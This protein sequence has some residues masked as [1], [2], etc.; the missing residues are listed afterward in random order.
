MSFLGSAWPEGPTEGPSTCRAWLNPDSTD[1]AVS[2]V[3]D[4]AI[5]AFLPADFSIIAPFREWRLVSPS[6]IRRLE[7]S[8]RRLSGLWS[9]MPGTP[10]RSRFPAPW[11]ISVAPIGYPFTH[12]CAGRAIPRPMRKTWSRVSWEDWI[13]PPETRCRA[14]SRSPGRTTSVRRLYGPHIR[15]RRDCTHRRGPG[16]ARR[17][18]RWS[19]VAS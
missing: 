14:C 15:N 7:R 13:T 3:E 5:G 2:I 16:D 11:T 19:R 1:K 10:A 17:G 4:Y 18:C 12:S 6:P 8:S 9:F